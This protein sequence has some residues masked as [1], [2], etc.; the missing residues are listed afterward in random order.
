M[1]SSFH[2]THRLLFVTI[3]LTLMHFIVSSIYG[4]YIAEK[5]G[6]EMG[7]VVAQGLMKAYTSSDSSTET[8]AD[9]YEGMKTQRNALYE[10]WRIQFFILSLPSGPLMNPFW[11]SLRDKWIYSPLLS[12]EIFE[13]QSRTRGKIIDNL[14]NMVNSISFGL[15]IYLLFRVWSWRKKRQDIG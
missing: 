1:I 9:I 14:A 5:V 11:Q 3:M 12:K 13:D 10:R 7:H 2:K 6:A 4:H 8:A 15:I